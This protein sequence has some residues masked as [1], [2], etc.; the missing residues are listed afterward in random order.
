[1]YGSNL[2]VS[3]IFIQIVSFHIRIGVGTFVEVM[4]FGNNGYWNHES[5]VI[6]H[7]LIWNVH[8]FTNIFSV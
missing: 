4:V 1:M 6:N 5:H 7:E 3:V 2:L 8:S